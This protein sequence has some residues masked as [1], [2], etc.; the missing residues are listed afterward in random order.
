MTSRNK[1]GFASIILILAVVLFG[2]GCKTIRIHAEDYQ[3]I[4]RDNPDKADALFN[5]GV[6]LNILKR[7]DEAISAF[8]TSLRL[9]PDDA[10]TNFRLG[11]I[12]IQSGMPDKAK[13]LLEKALENDTFEALHG[14]KGL[15]YHMIGNYHKSAEEF[16]IALQE[17]EPHPTQNLCNMGVSFLQLEKFEKAA[18][19]FKRAITI[20]PAISVEYSAYF[21]LGLAYQQMDKLEDALECYDKACKNTPEKA[22]I[23]MNRILIYVSME[24]WDNVREQIAY[25]RRLNPETAREFIEQYLSAYD[26]QTD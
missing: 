25:L 16:M 7:N 8:K 24:K 9:D 18:A 19:A 1:I 14:Q 21:K 4:I 11:M 23:Y 17:D 12:Y 20:S 6:A 13:P 15:A 5:R 2:T 10:E 3:Q 26:F 22:E